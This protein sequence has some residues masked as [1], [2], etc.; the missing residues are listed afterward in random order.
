M[1]ALEEGL[2][3]FERKY[4]LRSETFYTAYRSGEEEENDAWVLDFGEWTSV[5]QTWLAGRPSTGMRSSG[6]KVAHRARRG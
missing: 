6:S 1:P 3:E 5:Y 4:D 2:L